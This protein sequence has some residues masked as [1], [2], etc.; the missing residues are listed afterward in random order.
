MAVTQDLGGNIVTWFLPLG[1]PDKL[2]RSVFSGGG[3]ALRLRKTFWPLGQSTAALPFFLPTTFHLSLLQSAPPK[4]ARS[5]VSAAVLYRL[6]DHQIL[7]HCNHWICLRF[8]MCARL[9]T[10]IHWVAS[11]VFVAI[12]LTLPHQ[13]ILSCLISY[14]SFLSKSPESSNAKTCHNH[15][16]FIWI[17]ALL[18]ISCLHSVF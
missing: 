5:D 1:P 14:G 9:C 17:V 18:Q 15:K 12:G 8:S 13:T 11:V 7:C 6:L 10:S 4:Q 2:V 16:A 3:V